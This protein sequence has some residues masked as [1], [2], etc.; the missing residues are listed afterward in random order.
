MNMNRQM[1]DNHSESWLMI[2]IHAVGLPSDEKC[3]NRR[4]MFLKSMDG[5]PG[6]SEIFLGVQL[7]DKTMTY[8]IKTLL[9]STMFFLF[10]FILSHPKKK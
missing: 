7:C 9:T 6:G 2:E 1:E 3:C 5:N 4:K 10:V 8:N